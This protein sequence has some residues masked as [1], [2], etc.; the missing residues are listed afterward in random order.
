MTT[1][2]DITG[3][4]IR[5][6]AA[7]DKFRENFDRVFGKPKFKITYGRFDGD[8]PAYRSETITADNLTYALHEAEKSGW[9]VKG[10][11]VLGVERV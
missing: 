2:N 10:W 9:V 3:D 4:A 11:D 7:N 5:S 8:K 1:T 6:K